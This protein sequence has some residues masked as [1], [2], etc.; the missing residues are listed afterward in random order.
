MIY[1]MPA[2]PLARPRKQRRARRKAWIFG[3]LIALLAGAYTALALATPFAELQPSVT[4]DQLRITTQSS[5]LPWPAYGQSAFGLTDG[6]VI[7]TRGEQTPVAIAS[8]SK[9]INALVVLDKYPMAPGESGPT[10]TMTAQDVASYNQYIAMNGSVMPVRAGQKLTQRDMLEALLLPSANNIADSLAIWAFGSVDAYLEYAN[11]YLQKKGLTN[12]RVGGD[13]SGYSADSVSTASDLVKL[14]ALALKNPVVAE[15]VNQKTAVIP[16]V[17]T[18]R[19]YNSLLGSN[20]IVGV[21]TGNND[22]N[23]G[24]FLGATTTQVNGKTVTIISALSGAET[25]GQVLRDSGTF[26]AAVRTT[27]AQ[28]SIV[29]KGTV[30]GTYEQQDGTHVQAV[31]AEDL[32]MMVLRGS[33]V[34][35]DVKLRP[36]GYDAAAG[37]TVGSVSIA[38]SDYSPLSSIPVVLAKEP[39]QP[40]LMYRLTHPGLVLEFFR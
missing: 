15:I 37:Q 28:T 13:A 23:G 12:T 33:T 21:K 9:V 40:S 19:N 24:V 26:L 32:G 20:G 14:G 4:Q 17:G 7:A 25:L 39:T 27:F 18:V 6:T 31:A 29:Q 11:Q 35:A 16:E 8:V 2:R 1:L 38:A 34:T 3:L 30:L 5:N 22:E 36:I 10:I